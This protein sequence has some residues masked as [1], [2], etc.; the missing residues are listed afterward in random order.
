M[1]AIVEPDA[2]RSWVTCIVAAVDD[3]HAARA[4]DGNGSPVGAVFEI[5]GSVHGDRGGELGSADCRE[6]AHGVGVGVGGR[7]HTVVF[8]EAQDA[9]ASGGLECTTV[10]LWADSSA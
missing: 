2:E 4:A 1:A 5:D 10:D 7:Q 3:D 6:E 9:E 8:A